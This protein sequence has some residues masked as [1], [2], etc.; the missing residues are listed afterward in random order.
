MAIPY[1]RSSTCMT[2]VRDMAKTQTTD[3]N[4]PTTSRAACMVPS[5]WTAA[6]CPPTNQSAFRRVP[7]G[8]AR[9]A[10]DRL[11][12]KV[13]WARYKATGRRRHQRDGQPDGG[14][15]RG[16]G[17]D[18]ALHQA[19]FE[20]RLCDTVRTPP[21]PLNRGDAAGRCEHRPS[22]QLVGVR[23]DVDRRSDGTTFEPPSERCSLESTL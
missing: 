2:A 12:C 6:G 3:D 15:R 5:T 14:I 18:S 16:R 19:M 10:M 22:F 9:Q 4:Q 17:G 13:F 21:G 23:R 7:Y 1:R 8:W 20:G 11:G